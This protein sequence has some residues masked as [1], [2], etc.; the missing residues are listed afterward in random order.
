MQVNVE[1]LSPVLVEFQVE[2]PAAQVRSEVDK[3][4]VALRKAQIVVSD[5]EGQPGWYR[6]NLKVRPHFKYMGAA[7]ELSLVGKLDKE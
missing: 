3:A 5:V 4:Y 6:V 2:V 7:F 1:Q